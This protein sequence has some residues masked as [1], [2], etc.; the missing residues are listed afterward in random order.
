AYGPV[1]DAACASDAVASYYA[2]C[3]VGIPTQVLALA[4][5]AAGVAIGKGKIDSILLTTDYV[6]RAI[7]HILEEVWGC[8]VF[9]HYGMTEMGLGGG[10]EC[11]ALDGYHLR[12]GD[13]YFEVVDHET[14]D[15]C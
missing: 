1:T 10:V 14:G 13:L 3:L 9:T 8:R 5:S 4:R 7:A 11:E 2:H 12:E 6:P 15:A